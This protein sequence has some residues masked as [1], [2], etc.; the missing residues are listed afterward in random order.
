MGPQL[1]SAPA[2]CCNSS[3]LPGSSHPKTVEMFK[4]WLHGSATVCF[5]EGLWIG[6]FLT[7]SSLTLLICRF[8]HD[9]PARIPVSVDV[10]RFTNPACS[11]LKPPGVSLYLQSYVR[12]IRFCP[13]NS[14]AHGSTPFLL[15]KISIFM[16]QVPTFPPQ[17]SPLFLLNIL[18][19]IA[20]FPTCSSRIP[21]FMHQKSCLLT[22]LLVSWLKW[23]FRKIG[24]PPNHHL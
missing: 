15:L 5:D 12:S 17:N 22:S 21:V 16:A 4:A 13:Q 23:G 6:E 18:T 20:Q 1:Q 7:Q 14:N 2:A 10:P 9:F 11:T 19:F 3:K 8:W 24:L